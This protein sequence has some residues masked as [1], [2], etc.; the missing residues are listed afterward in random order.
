[1]R[2]IISH[3]LTILGFLLAI[4]LIARLMRDNR[5]PGSTMAWLMAIILIPYIGI[6]F[7]FLFGGSKVKFLIN[8]KSVIY[9]SQ[10]NDDLLKKE[11]VYDTEKIL[12]KGGGSAGS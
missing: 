11:Y 4:I 3:L 7:Y 2:L 1:M 10:P 8:K 12:V 6:P 5:H 9:S